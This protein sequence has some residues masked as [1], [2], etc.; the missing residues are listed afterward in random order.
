M[1]V[2]IENDFG[3]RMIRISTD[4]VISIVRGYQNLTKNTKSYD[5][6]RNILS[7]NPFYI[8]ED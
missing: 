3:R 1:A 8:P 6:I 2:V 4:D 7:L 5:S